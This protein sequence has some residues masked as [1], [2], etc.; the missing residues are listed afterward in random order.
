MT[1]YLHILDVLRRLAVNDVVHVALIARAAGVGSL[2]ER[3][4]PVLPCPP[5]VA[6]VEQVQVGSAVV[7]AGGHHRLQL[8][9]VEIAKSRSYHAF[10]LFFLPPCVLH[11]LPEVLVVV[12]QVGGLEVLEDG[13]A[14]KAVHLAVGVV[15]L[16]IVS[17]RSGVED[18]KEH[19][20]EILHVH[21]VGAQL[22]G[23]VVGVVGTGGVCPCVL[24][25]QHVDARPVAVL[26]LLGAEGGAHADPVL[27]NL[28]II[29]VLHLALHDVAEAEVCPA[30]ERGVFVAVSAIDN[31][32]QVGN[33]L[34]VH[35]DRGQCLGAGAA[36][37][38]EL[39]YVGVVVGVRRRVLVDA[40]STNEVGEAVRGGL[41]VV[42]THHAGQRASALRLTD[43]RLEG[44]VLVLFGVLADAYELAHHVPVLLCHNS[45]L[46]GLRAAARAAVVILVVIL[47]GGNDHA[48]AHSECGHQ[49]P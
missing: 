3:Q 42:H 43:G 12:L 33:L 1:V 8:A 4:V 23:L 5:R 32:L 36:G 25:G 28:F 44:F 10:P 19:L 49:H 11:V 9:I 31:L 15:G 37:V 41:H 40:G 46:L 47:A 2:V 24:L 45:L 48:K 22:G 20:G 35:L 14:V 38:G 29:P 16:G 39:A 6:L 17:P 7:V 30:L 27:V 18:G 13:Y 34:D 26:L 21:L